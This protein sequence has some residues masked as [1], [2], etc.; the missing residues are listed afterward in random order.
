MIT[1]GSIVRAVAD[2]AFLAAGSEGSVAI[3]EAPQHDCDWER[4]RAITGLDA[5]RRL[6]RPRARA[7]A[8]DDRSAPRGRRLPRR[9]DRRAPRAAGRSGRLSPRRSRRRAAPS[10]GSGLDPRRFRGADY[11]PGPT[12]RHHTEGRN[13]YLLSET[14]LSADLV[15]NL[16]EA[17]D[18]QEDRRHARAQ[19]PGRHQRRQEPAA[20]SLC[21]LARA[22]R[23]RVP[24]RRRARP[25]AQRAPPRWRARC[26]RAGS[27][28]GSCAGCGAPRTPRAA[29]RSSAAA[30]GTATR[31]PGACAST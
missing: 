26:S 31:P 4:I 2:Y 17:Q 15:V 21:R 9:R 16:P 10:R 13:E 7:R 24:G 22:G 23:R 18:A 5:A 14:V 28:R 11:D 3:A 20:A 30:T 12:S 27:A 19:E 1:H 8:R 25:P 6:L 29:T